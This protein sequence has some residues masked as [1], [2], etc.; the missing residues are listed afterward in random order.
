MEVVKVK[1]EEKER[2]YV[3]DNDGLPIEPILKFIRFKD[4][5][6]YAR[7]TLRMYCQHLKLYFEYLEQRGLDFQKVTIDDLSL[8]VNWLQNPYKSLKV[9]PATPVDTARSPRTVN[10]IVDTV[11]LFYDYILRHEEYSNDVSERLKK[12]VTSSSRNFKG[13][14]YEIAYDKKKV[15]SNILKLKVPKS[16]PKTLS[17]DEI[18]MLVRA[19][20]NLRD[21][22][23]L[24]LLYETGMR[25][26]ETLSLWIEDID[27]SDMVIDLK[28]R[29]QLENNAE[30]KTVSSPRR[31]DISQNLADMFMEY[32]AEYHNEE[33]E[34]NHIFIK[35]SGNNKNKAMHYV[36]V[37]NLFRSLKKKT[38]IYVT[39]HMFRHSSLTVLRMAGWQP[40]LLRVRAG[41][42]N[43]YTTMNT[44][45]HP[46]DEDITREFEKTQPNLDLDIYNEGEE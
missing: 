21:K 31:I 33:V 42:K 28:D 8:F 37:D 41:H 19:C 29:G 9:I 6:N 25:I 16:K 30:I 38:G 3:A 10:I 1:T 5:T 26:G 2:Y 45:I 23:L 11:L 43:I 17:K 12:F 20:S 13:F 40:E 35:I 36:D 15:T 22:F 4:N 34:T 27:I 7:N 39:P 24:S 32:I 18:E 14:L 44:Y 46:S